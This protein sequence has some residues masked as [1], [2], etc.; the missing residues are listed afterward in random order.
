MTV[1]SCPELDALGVVLVLLTLVFTLG[2]ASSLVFWSL[3][4]LILLA[5]IVEQ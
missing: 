4:S 2:V 1:A 3:V 5:V